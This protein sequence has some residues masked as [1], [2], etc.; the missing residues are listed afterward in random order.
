MF[1]FVVRM[2][3]TAH[4]GDRAHMA[5]CDAVHT[6]HHLSNSEF[7][8]PNEQKQPHPEGRSCSV[9]PPY[10]AKDACRKAGEACASTRC[11][12]RTRT[13]LTCMNACFTP[14]SVKR[15]SLTRRVSSLP[16]GEPLSLSA[17]TL[18]YSSPFASVVCTYLQ[19]EALSILRPS[20]LSGAWAYPAAVQAR[21][22]E[23]AKPQASFSS[24]FTTT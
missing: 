14:R 19:C 3:Q 24:F 11:N 13:K 18:R 7:I 2:S 9:V 17:R 12:G 8:I 5:D 4:A 23:E 1:F 16:A 15:P 6:G 22:I 20:M 21:R 10:F